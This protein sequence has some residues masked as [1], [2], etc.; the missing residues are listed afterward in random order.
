MSFAPPT[1]SSWS[2][3]TFKGSVLTWLDGLPFVSLLVLA[4]LAWPHTV[5]DAYI[6]FRYSENFVNGQGLVFNPGE[7]VEGFSNPLWVYLMMA[8]ALL[9]VDPT[10]VAKVLGICAAMATALLISRILER[11]FAVSNAVRHPALFVFCGH[12]S[13][14][15]YA[16]C[17]LETSTYSLLI[18]VLHY[19]LLEKRYLLA[20][21]ATG[22]TA[23]C[24]PEGAMLLLSLGTG[25]ALSSSPKRSLRYLIVPLV[26][27]A[28]QLAFR[29]EY[30]GRWLP[31][32]FYAKAIVH[33]K[34]AELL[35]HH[36]KA[37]IVGTAHWSFSYL[38]GGSLALAGV[39]GMVKFWRIHPPMLVS[40]ALLCFFIWYSVFDWMAFGRFYLPLL[41][42]LL[43]YAFAALNA[44]WEHFGSRGRQSLMIAAAA[45]LVL[46]TWGVTLRSLRRL[47]Y[48]DVYAPA[49]SAR[50][51]VAP[52]LYMREHGRQGDL[53]AAPEIGAL[54]Y[55]SR[56]R[57]LDLLGLTDAKIPAMLG[58]HELYGTLKR[59]DLRGYADY[60]L[61]K[62]PQFVVI[63]FDRKGDTEVL[64]ALSGCLY[65]EMMRQHSHV[66][67]KKFRINE[68]LNLGVFM[69]ADR[70]PPGRDRGPHPD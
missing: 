40:I 70:I 7:R 19:A 48:G 67:V 44:A 43:T 11:H 24:R 16:V 18:V 12:I 59:A 33:R 2:G 63:Y 54:A 1:N 64:S 4:A 9:G 68:A 36:T 69:A 8:P 51:Y 20:A 21:V 26:I 52:A 60:V 42:L 34:L 55:F 66:L 57:M 41:P 56:L 28:A 58:P 65:D 50:A 53:V 46:A 35:L 38:A 61:A 62:H 6:S 49:M 47:H 14:V 17:G 39:V 23:I 27:V 15:Y 10:L 31:N 25:L 5:D 13:V 45:A 30:Y 22:L 3:G 37:F 29:H 32:T